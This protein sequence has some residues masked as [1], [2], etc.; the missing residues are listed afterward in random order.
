MAL[1]VGCPSVGFGVSTV[2]GFFSL[3]VTDEFRELF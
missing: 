1:E 2:E 3:V